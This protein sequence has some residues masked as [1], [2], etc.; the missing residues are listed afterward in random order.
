[1]DD[2]QKQMNDIVK[3]LDKM[4]Y[5]Y[6]LSINK[7]EILKRAGSPAVGNLKGRATAIKD[8]GKLASSVEFIL[9]RAKRAVYI[10]YNY[11]KAKHGHL[12]EFG[13]TKR[14]G[15]YQAGLGI[16]KKTYEAT[17]ADIL[18]KLQVELEKITRSTINKIKVA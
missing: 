15:E 6:D 11:K 17:K 1:M 4:S 8:T 10:G 14:N 13:W 2:V 5:E 3:K 16:V 12:I 9:K 7:K 18:K